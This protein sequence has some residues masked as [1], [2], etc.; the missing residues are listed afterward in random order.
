MKKSGTHISVEML[1]M[2]TEKRGMFFRDI[3]VRFMMTPPSSMPTATA[4]RFMAPT[5]DGGGGRRSTPDRKETPA[6]V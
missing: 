6:A 2:S 1:N 5:V 4:G 3:P